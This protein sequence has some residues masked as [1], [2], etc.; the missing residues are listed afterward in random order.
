[1]TKLMLVEEAVAV[2]AMAVVSKQNIMSTLLVMLLSVVA[3]SCM[4][5]LDKVVS[6]ITP[7][8]KLARRCARKVTRSF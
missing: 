4:D 7:V 2:M 1:M 6:L 5:D 8:P 3:V